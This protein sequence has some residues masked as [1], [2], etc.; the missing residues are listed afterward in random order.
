MANT[1]VKADGGK[2]VQENVV[3]YAPERDVLPVVAYGTT[4][5]GRSTITT[6]AQYLAGLGDSKALSEARREAL[7]PQIL[8]RSIAH[9]IIVIEPAE[10][11]KSLVCAMASRIFCGSVELAR[12]MASMTTM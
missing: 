3:T 9:S 5:F 11:S 10:P 6:A 1:Q 2:A 4:L 8:A 12:L 7:F